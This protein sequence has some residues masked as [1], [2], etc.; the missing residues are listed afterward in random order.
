M[1]R[2]LLFLTL[3]GF[4]GALVLSVAL[5]LFLPLALILLKFAVVVALLAALGYLL[6]CLFDPPRATRYAQMAK[7]KFRDFSTPSASAPSCETDSPR[8]VPI[9]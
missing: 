7:Q 5:V 6:L 3:V 2:A 4:V 8:E 1:L 9:E